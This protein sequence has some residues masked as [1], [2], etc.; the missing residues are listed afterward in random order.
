ML[1][2]VLESGITPDFVVCLDAEN[3]EKTFDGLDE[4]LPKINCITDVKASSCVFE[5]NFKKTFVTFSENEMVTKKLKE[6]NSSIKTYETGGSA[7]TMAFVAAVKMGFS[8]VIFSGLDLAFKNNVMY[9][10]GEEIQKIDDSTMKFFS[11][12]KKLT[13]VPS[14]TGAN[15]LTRED[16]AAFIKH[17]ETLIREMGYQGAYNTTSFGAK[18]EGMKN[19]PLDEISLLVTS[20]T[21]SIILGEAKPFKIETKEWTQAELYLINAVISLLSNETFSPA[22]VS[23]IVKS[24]ILYEYLQA[25][26]LKVLQSRMDDGLAEEF[27][28]KTKSAI[29]EVVD[30][31]Q[32]NRLI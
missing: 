1:R 28:G 27:L 13:E 14:V 5:K 24:P 4:Y 25:D 18:I 7:A 10:T 31:L 15:V 8:K 3:V 9:S 2:Q 32:R 17:F 19:K 22:L 20:N 6:F 30:I 23:A 21:T 12:D 11:K 29:K 26:I 16:Y